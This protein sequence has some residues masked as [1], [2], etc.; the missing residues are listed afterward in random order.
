MAD[1]RLEK[2]AL[3]RSWTAEKVAAIGSAARKTK[4]TGGTWKN[5]SD[6]NRKL[7]EDGKKKC[8]T[9]NKTKSITDFTRHKNTWDGIDTQCRACKQEYKD[10]FYS[11]PKNAARRDIKQAL[12]IKNNPEKVA[13]Q[14]KKSYMKNRLERIASTR[15]YAL[16]HPEEAAASKKEWY[17]RNS[18][19]QSIRMA[20]RNKK[21][22]EES[23]KALNEFYR[24]NKVPKRLWHKEEFGSEK[25]LQAAI[26]HVISNKLKLD[27]EREKHLAKGARVDIY[28]D[29]MKLNIEV[30]FGQH[31][32]VGCRI[33][34]IEEQVARYSEH[35]ETVLVSLNGEPKDWNSDCRWFTPRQLFNFISDRNNA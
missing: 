13:E 4:P 30:K 5:H 23:T 7:A 16:E 20:A 29:A 17:K 28:L 22:R 27:V 2:I 11:D 19:V 6:L 10:K 18:K 8:G 32:A 15:K 1:K 33:K 35:N 14:S 31:D 26:A 34:K 24:K 25:D 9:C 21:L 12:Y 3:E